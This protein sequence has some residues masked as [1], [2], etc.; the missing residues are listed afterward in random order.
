MVHDPSQWFRF[1]SLLTAHYWDPHIHISSRQVRHLHSNPANWP[2]IP[3]M[4]KRFRDPTR[5]KWGQQLL[6]QLQRRGLLE[7]YYRK[8]T[9]QVCGSP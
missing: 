5:K 3:Y 1:V 6:S 2:L 8:Q 7:T 4:P 9:C